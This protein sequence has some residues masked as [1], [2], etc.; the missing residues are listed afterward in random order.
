[1][2]DLVELS[3]VVSHVLR[4]EPWR[5][6]LE[7]DED[8]WARVDQVLDALHAKGGDW[9]LVD[10]GLLERMIASSTKRRHELQGNRIR[11]LYRHSLPGM[12]K[13][14]PAQPR[15]GCFTAQLRRP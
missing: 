6:E 12:I 14:T 13:K 7:L 3:R 10:H 2:M 11:A 15:H 5:Y 8:G 9:A 4:H 1:M